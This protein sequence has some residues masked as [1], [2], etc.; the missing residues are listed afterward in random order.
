MANR[1]FAEKI[2]KYQD[3]SGHKY[4]V[5]ADLIEGKRPAVSI[6]TGSEVVVIEAEDWDV[7]VDCVRRGIE[8]IGDHPESDD[9]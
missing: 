9:N 2:M 1:H 7:I 6:R 8:A 5:R 3:N 4:E